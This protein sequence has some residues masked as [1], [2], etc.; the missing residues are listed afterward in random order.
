MALR[1]TSSTSGY[2]YRVGIR[3]NLV[4]LLTTIDGVTFD[5][6]WADKRS[7]ELDGRRIHYIGRKTLLA[8]KRAAGR[9]KDLADAAWLEAHPEND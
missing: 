2:G 5:Q 1:R 4:E 3:P 8:N 7:F 9:A 6:A